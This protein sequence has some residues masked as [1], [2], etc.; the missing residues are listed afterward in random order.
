MICP[1]CGSENVTISIQQSSSKTKKHGNGLGAY[2]T[3]RRVVLQLYV[4]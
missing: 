3:T 1:N 2:L 4:R